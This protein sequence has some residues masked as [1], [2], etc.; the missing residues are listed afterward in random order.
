MLGFGIRSDSLAEL[1]SVYGLMFGPSRVVCR[2]QVA[3][4]HEN[5]SGKSFPDSSVDTFNPDHNGSVERVLFYDFDQRPGS[6]SKRVEELDNLRGGRSGK[7]DDTGVAGLEFVEGRDLLDAVGLGS[8]D[9][10]PVWAGHRTTEFLKEAIFDFLREFVFEGTGKLISF[11]PGVPEHVGEEPLH[12]PMASNRCD[13]QS[14]PVSCQ[15]YPLVRAMID[16][17]ALSQPFDRGGDR[18]G[19]DAEV[20]GK[21][22]RMGV[23]A[24]L[25]KAVHRFQH[26]AVGLGDVKIHDDESQN[27]DFS[28]PKLQIESGLDSSITSL[29]VA[30]LS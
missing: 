27:L 6:D 10:E 13:G 29:F 11:V 30:V 2:H 23:G 14:T 20:L 19:G 7:G 1:P 16:Q 12:D 8:G 24:A 18:S 17:V 25:R 4:L 3:G 28:Y 5:L 9:G 26:F 15:F 22:A 21:R